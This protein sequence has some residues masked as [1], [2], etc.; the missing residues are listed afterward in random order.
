MGNVIYLFKGEY[1]MKKEVSIFD[2]ADTLLSFESMTNKKLQ[3]LCY[4]AQAWHLA[5]IGEPLVNEKFQ[6]WIHGPV[7][8]KLYNKYKM[9]GWQYIESKEAPRCIRENEE[10]Y[11]FLKQIYRIYGELDG[12]EL[13]QLSHMER[14]WIKA[15]GNLEP[16]EA[17]QESIDEEDM[18]QFYLEEFER[19]QN[20]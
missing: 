6:A 1:V 19:S 20:D 15:R 7:C 4:Y 14:P 16:W 8:P 10:L 3:K 2:V 11:N 9:Y 17:S 18:R 13:E 5:L 12:N